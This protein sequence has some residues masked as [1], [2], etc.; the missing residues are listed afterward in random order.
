MGVE[1]TVEAQSKLVSRVPSRVGTLMERVEN[2]SWLHWI[3]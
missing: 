3:H 1:S 2:I